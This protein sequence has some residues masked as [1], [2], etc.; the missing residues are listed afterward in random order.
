[1][2]PGLIPFAVDEIRRRFDPQDLSSTGDTSIRFSWRES[3]EPLLDLRTAVALY[4]VTTFSGRRPSSLLGDQNLQALASRISWITHSDRGQEFSSF[5]LSAA[6]ATTSVYRRLTDELSLATGLAFDEEEGELLIRV[7]PAAESRAWEVL[8]R[9]TP[10]PLSTRRWRVCDMA[11]GLNATVAA[12]MVELSDPV[13]HDTF[14][15]PMCGSG[16]LIIER[17]HR[18]AASA[19]L[20]FDADDAAIRCTNQNLRAAGLLVQTKVQLADATASPVSNGTVDKVCVNP[21]WGGLVGS[22]SE[23]EILYPALLREM[24]RITVPRARM[25][26]LTHDVRR[27]ERHLASQNQWVA[28]ES[29]RVFQKGHHPRIYV[30]TKNLSTQSLH[31]GNDLRSEFG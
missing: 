25:I 13:P 6:G 26:L 11:G 27:F 1:M 9:L 28:H 24:A 16:T 4:L 2:L 23:N 19:V 30:L 5:R 20:G 17:L 21:P 18:S 22:H 14:L 31:P 10:R 12:A 7:R 3:I 15:D 8:L 29:V